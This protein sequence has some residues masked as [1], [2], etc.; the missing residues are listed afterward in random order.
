MLYT[1]GVFKGLFYKNCK[2][3]LALKGIK[4]VFR[5]KISIKLTKTF[6]LI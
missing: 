3:D 4:N 1:F 2:L 5:Y 6:F